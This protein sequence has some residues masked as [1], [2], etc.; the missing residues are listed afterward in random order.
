MALEFT[1]HLPLA[2]IG[3]FLQTVAPIIFVVLYGVAHLVGNL[4]QE[5]RKPPVRP[6]Q[7]PLPPELGERPLA[8]GNAPA[9]GN[10]PNLEETLRREVEEFL[11]RAQGQ[12]PQQPKPAPP[13]P[14]QLPPQRPA[15]QRPSPPPPRPV[16][17][18]DRSAAPPPPRRLVETARAETPVVPTEPLRQTLGAPPVGAGLPTHVGDP[19][20]T[21]HV[22]E[23][24]QHLGAEVAQADERMQQHLREKFVHQ[25]GVLA[26]RTPSGQRQAAANSAAQEL[27]NLIGRPNGIKQLIIAGEILRR[28]EER[29]ERQA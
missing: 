24:A 1:T 23:H 9:A 18:P 26:P 8:G 6:R 27:R 21:Q 12:P 2:D 14:Q 7:R 11:R 20:R 25:V 22:A 19:L 10:Q 29:W 15:A 13:R 5:K 17:Q 4:Q 3:E 28:P 16:R